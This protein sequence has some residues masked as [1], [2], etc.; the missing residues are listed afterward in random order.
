MGTVSALALAVAV[1]TDVFSSVDRETA[2]LMDAWVRVRM[3]ERG[4]FLAGTAVIRAETALSFACS[5]STGDLPEEVAK[6]WKRYLKA[7]ADC[8]FNFQRAIGDVSCSESEE[9]LLASFA[10]W[11]TSGEEFLNSVQS[12]R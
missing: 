9:K 3:D 10:R 2:G 11:T 12:T 8:L 6:Q 7:S 5:A 1:N 4:M